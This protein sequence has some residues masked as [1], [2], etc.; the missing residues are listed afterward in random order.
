[1]ISLDGTAGDGGASFGLSARGEQAVAYV[2]R[3][4]VFNDILRHYSDRLAS[5]QPGSTG[6]DS[7]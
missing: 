4:R 7:L 6:S 1:M 5:Y 2:A 3:I